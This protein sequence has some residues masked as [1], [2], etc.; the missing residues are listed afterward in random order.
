MRVVSS[1]APRKAAIKMMNHESSR[2]RWDVIIIINTV[3]VGRVRIVGAMI[4]ERERLTC[5]LGASDPV[6]AP[7]SASSVY[8][9]AIAFRDHARYTKARLSFGE[10]CPQG[11]SGKHGERRLLCPSEY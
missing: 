1:V 6:I 7:L 8:V 4:Y 11:R 10:A 5:P 9:S 2:K 3:V